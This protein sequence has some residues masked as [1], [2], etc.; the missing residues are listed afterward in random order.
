[1]IAGSRN[2]SYY[3]K[4]IGDFCQEIQIQ[5]RVKVKAKVEVE[6]KIKEK[7]RL[8]LEDRG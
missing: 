8:N 3:S 5:E 7:K 4:K 2:S 6:E 1:M